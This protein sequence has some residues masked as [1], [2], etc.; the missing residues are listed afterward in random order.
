MYSLNDKVV[1]VTG[2][3]SGIGKAAAYQFAALG[4]RVVLVARRADVLAEVKNDLSQYGDSILAVPA[5]VTKEQDL[6]NLYRTVLETFGEI[7][8]LVN[9]AGISVGGEF[10]E[11]NADELRKMVEVN[12]YAPMR[13]AQLV[14]PSMLERKQGHIV[15]VSS[16]AG[17]VMSPGQTAYAS[18][19]SAVIAFSHALRREV[20]GNGVRVSLILPGWTRTPMLDKMDLDEMRAVKVLTPFTTLDDPS[21]PARAIVDSVLHN[22]RQVLLGGSQIWVADFMG[23]MSPIRITDWFYNFILD[24]AKLV[25]VMKDLG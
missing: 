20:S 14:L 17:L 5:D 11:H 22:R 3:S 12:V 21:V 23:R 19:R 18:T 2:A 15:N 6:Q 16:V 8:V 13:L 9:N 1:I 24:K 25:K 10:Q 7:D 4:A